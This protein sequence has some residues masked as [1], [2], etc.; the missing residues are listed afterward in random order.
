MKKI[1]MPFLFLLILFNFKG[2]TQIKNS[3]RF[4]YMVPADKAFNPL[5]VPGIENVAIDLQRWFNEQL[6]GS[7]FILNNPIVE[8][9]NSDKDAI[10]FQENP[11]IFFPKRFWPFE[12]ALSEAHRTLG[13]QI[14]DPNHAWVVFVDTPDINGAGKGHFAYLTGNDLEIIT[15]KNKNIS[16]F[17]RLIGGVGHELGH[18]YGL[19]HSPD[20]PENRNAIMWS[21]IHTYP[22]AFLTE[23]EKTILRTKDAKKFFSTD[24]YSCEEGVRCYD[25]DNCTLN[26]KF[27]TNCNCIPGPTSDTPKCLDE[28]TLS[29]DN[30]FLKN[31]NKQSLLTIAPN[32]SNGISTLMGIS[33]NDK[34][35]IIDVQGNPVFN[36]IAIDNELSIDTSQWATGVYFINVNQGTSTIKLIRN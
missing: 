15:G 1:I 17:D 14:F 35:K 11:N 7:T 12:N 24:A 10:W 21:G 27:D 8:V 20:I 3:T 34:I 32:P 19:P 9:I 29:L 4:I 6:D 25:R 36:S 13:A 2:F 30:N 22:D 5:Y 28:S 18:A 23:D 33:K 26:D 31:Q 16:S